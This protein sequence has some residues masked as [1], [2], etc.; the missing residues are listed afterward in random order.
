MVF[1][2]PSELQLKLYHQ[3]LRCQLIRSCLSGA[4]SG[5]PHLICIGALKQLC[6]HPALLYHKARKH[7]ATTEESGFDE[8]VSTYI[9]SSVIVQIP[10]IQMITVLMS[11]AHDRHLGMTWHHTFSFCTINWIRVYL[12]LVLTQLILLLSER[13]LWSDGI[14]DHNSWHRYLLEHA[15]SYQKMI[16]NAFSY[17][18]NIFNKFL[19]KQ[20][21][22]KKTLTILLRK[23]I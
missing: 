11:P 9:G 21:T 10:S 3:L 23:T 15:F 2:Y 22:K 16:F 20:K 7:E 14:S 5:S 12:L 4:L 8:A 1:C 18:K 17:Q 13:S 6:N 19:K